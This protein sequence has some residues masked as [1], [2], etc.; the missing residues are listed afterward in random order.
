M[1]KERNKVFEKLSPQGTVVL[2]ATGEQ[3]RLGGGSEFSLT[4]ASER[5]VGHPLTGGVL[6]AEKFTRGISERIRPDRL[7]FEG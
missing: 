3:T 5:L 1:R 4:F 2:L 7:T 6:A